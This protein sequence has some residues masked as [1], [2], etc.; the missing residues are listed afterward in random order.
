MLLKTLCPHFIWVF[1]KVQMVSKQMF[2]EQKTVD[3]L[4]NENATLSLGGRHDPAIIHRAR[5]VQDAI[6]AI[7]LADALTLRFGTDYLSKD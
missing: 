5:A 6:T 3:F 2:K 1:Y 4:K 7:A